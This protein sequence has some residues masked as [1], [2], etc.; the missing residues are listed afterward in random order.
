[1]TSLAPQALAA[2]APGADPPADA[3]EI[4]FA[5]Q[6]RRWS[7]LALVPADASCDVSALAGALAEIGARQRGRQ[8]L[9]LSGEALDL[10]SAAALAA[11]MAAGGE[12]VLVALDALQS[13][14]AGMAV[15][16]AA[17]AAVLCV[18]RGESRMADARRIVERVGRD[19]FIGYVVLEEAR[20]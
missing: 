18:K 1:M 10:V 6:Q 12:P 3:Q 16:R 14:P 19:R 20:R 4:W 15:A 11:R 7:S 13:F 2:Q 5:L 8:P 9:L 17:D